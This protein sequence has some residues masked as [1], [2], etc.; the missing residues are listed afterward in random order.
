MQ[1]EKL[2]IDKYQPNKISDII[3]NRYAVDQICTWLKNHKN[4]VPK[5]KK[6]LL[7]A[8]QPG[9]GKSSTAHVIAKQ[10]GY[11]VI[12]F[13]ASDIRSK[14]SIQD[15]VV[16]ATDTQNICKIFGQDKPIL[17]IMDEVDGMSSG[18]KGG[19]SELIQIINP[20]KGKRNVKKEEKEKYEKRWIAPIICICNDRYS[21]KITDLLKVCKDVSFKTPTKLDLRD[22]VNTVT[23]NEGMNIDF[24]I[25]DNII[26][27][28]QNDIRRLIYI[29]QELHKKYGTNK[30]TLD[31]VNEL[32]TAYSKKNVDIGLF[33]A[34]NKLLSNNKLT[35]QDTLDLFEIDKNLVPLMLYENYLAFT[36][37]SI[38]INTVSNIANSISLG[39]TIT[40]LMYDGSYH[41]ELQS[42]YGTLAITVPYH[43][44]SNVGKELEELKFPTILGKMST[45]SSQRKLFSSIKTLC[46]LLSDIDSVL[47]LRKLILELILDDD[48]ENTLRALEIIDNLGEDVTLIDKFMKIKTYDDVDYKDLYK[49]KGVKKKIKNIMNEKN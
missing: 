39:D 21:K 32:Y 41:W 8:G 43:Y 27:Y 13:N 33:Q 6:A 24:D 29:L 11:D 3:G 25:I 17:I 31:D 47:Y 19:V 49:K 14:K 2:W 15:I 10:Y 18:D 23:K 35:I 16:D 4:K 46:P 48:K 34:V 38:S 1:S 40:G 22:L 7:I 37:K 30:I 28:S 9:I 36:K 12:E 5:T 42:L 20:L 26:E 44:I 45:Y